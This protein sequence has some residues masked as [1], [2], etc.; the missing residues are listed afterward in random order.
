VIRRR[1]ACTIST[2]VNSCAN[3]LDYNKVGTSF[4]VALAVSTPNLLQV[5]VKV[6]CVLSLISRYLSLWIDGNIYI[7][8][9]NTGSLMQVLNGHGSGSVNSVAWNPQ[10]DRV[11][12]SCSDDHTIRVWEVP[13]PDIEWVL[14]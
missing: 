3:S 5:E 9:Q 7:W 10:N 2:L 1:Y 13:S 11:L 4:G 8:H 6:C 14:V 12:A